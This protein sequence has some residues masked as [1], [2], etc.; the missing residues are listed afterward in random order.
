MSMYV[1]RIP[2]RN[3]LPAIVLRESSRDGDKIE[4]RTRANFEKLEALAVAA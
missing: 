2:N 3:S 4:E 1:E